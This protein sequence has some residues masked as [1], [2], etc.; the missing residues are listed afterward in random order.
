MLNVLMTTRAERYKVIKAVR[1]LVSLVYPLH[2]A[3]CLKWLD[4]VNIQFFAQ[5][6]FSNVTS[7]ATVVITLSSGAALPI[8]IGAVILFISAF[9]VVVF[10]ADSIVRLPNTITRFIAKM[11][12]VVLQPVRSCQY[13]GAASCTRDSN[14]IPCGVIRS[15]QLP[16]VI[17]TPAN[18]IAKE[19]LRPKNLVS[20]PIESSTASCTGNFYQHK[21]PLIGFLVT[22]S[23]FTNINKGVSEVYHKL[24]ALVNPEQHNYTT[25]VLQMAVIWH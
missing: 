15:Y 19:V 3:I 22:C 2:I 8:P 25:Y 9:P 17:L 12:A 20:L 4:V 1:I 23:G 24:M 6:L 21:I 14:A 13:L 7:L 11:I 18:E 10:F 5:L 16:R